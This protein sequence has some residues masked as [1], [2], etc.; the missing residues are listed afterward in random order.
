MQKKYTKQLL[1]RINEADNEDSIEVIVRLRDL[2]A[3]QRPARSLS[4][5]QQAIVKSEKRHAQQL[6]EDLVAYLYQLEN[7]G[8][9]VK[10]LDTSWLTHSVLVAVSPPILRKLAKREDVDL[11]DV[12]AE[13]K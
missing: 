8:A 9:K 12:N 3:L 13:F 1:R 4:R 5:S 11:L 2:E 7:K 6:V 10:L